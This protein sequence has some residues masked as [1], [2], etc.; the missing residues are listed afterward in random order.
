MVRRSLSAIAIAAALVFVGSAGAAG[1]RFSAKIVGNSANGRVA[2]HT[3]VVGDGYTGVFRDSRR[4]RTAY[5]VCWYRG[6]T[7]VGCKDGRTGRVGRDDTVFL[8]APSNTGL[9]DYRWIV[10]GRP[11]AHWSITIGIGD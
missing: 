3:F 8:I 6:G 4:A 10:A 9:Y 7:R 1:P 11:V 5:R 2:K